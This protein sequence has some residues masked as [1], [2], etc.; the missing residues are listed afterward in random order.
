MKVLVTGNKGY[1]GT[2]LT[3]ALKARGHSVRGLDSGLFAS[4]AVQ[5]IDPVAGSG[6]VQ[7]APHGLGSARL[8]P[9]DPA[10]DAAAKAAAWWIGDDQVGRS[11]S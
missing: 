3:T 1:I 7:G 10:G 2:G 6:S 4:C 5:P 8:E 11:S 9:E